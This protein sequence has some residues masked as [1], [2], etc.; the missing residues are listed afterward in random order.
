MSMELV[1]VLRNKEL[2]DQYQRSGV[3][4]IIVNSRF[5]IKNTFTE[6]E[7]I[8]INQYCRSKKIKFFVCVD[9]L[10]TE[11]DLEEL[12]K[13]L[14]FIKFLKPDG[15]YFADLAIL[16]YSKMKYFDCEMI[17]DPGPL[18]T[19]DLDISFFI[20]QK[21]GTVLARELTIKEIV[22]ILKKHPDKIDMQVFGH[23]RMSYSKRKFLT[24]YFKEIDENVVVDGVNDFTLVEENRSYKLPIREN[25]Y[26]T[27]IYTDYVLLMYEELAYLSR[28]L[29]RAIIDTD[30]ISE[31]IGFEVIRDIRRLSTENS[32]FLSDN[33]KN[34]HF[35]INFSNGYLYQKTTDKKVENE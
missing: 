13:Y 33:M 31:E 19:N 20:N 15:I 2:L 16:T 32:K 10:V 21:I 35:Y 7:L 25:K 6:E 26:G 3:H 22:E 24:N 27:T 29:K 11:S 14:D 34:S 1:A 28:V 9:A 30:F 4:G 18:N 12:H 8:I 5:S 23:L 17:Y